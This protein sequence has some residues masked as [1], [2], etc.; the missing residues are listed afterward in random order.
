[1]NDQQ[2]GV[3]RDIILAN[4][5][6]SLYADGKSTD[7]RE[8]AQLAVE[9]IDSGAALE[10][11]NHSCEFTQS[12]KLLFVKNY[13]TTKAQR[14]QRLLFREQFFSSVQSQK[15]YSPHVRHNEYISLWLCGKN[16]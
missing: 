7:I 4:S 6:A 11:L 9:S 16:L 13:F 15:H 8:G 12:L 1:M 5:A 2:K 10:V 14:T 3:K